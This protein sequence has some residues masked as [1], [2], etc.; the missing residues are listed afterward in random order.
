MSR[1]SGEDAKRGTLTLAR[2]DQEGDVPQLGQDSQ[3]KPIWRD[4]AFV[5]QFCDA[6][7][8]DTSLE[9]GHIAPSLRVLA[10]GM[11]RIAEMKGT[12]FFKTFS[13]REKA[14][15]DKAAGIFTT[16]AKIA[17]EYPQQSKDAGLMSVFIDRVLTELEK[18]PQGT[19]FPISGGWTGEDGGHAIM[20]VVERTSGSKG[21][22]TIC[23]TGQGV[24]HHPSSANFHPKIK[25][26][27]SIVLQ[28]V[29]WDRLVN[30]GFWAF[31]FA[32]NVFPEKINTPGRFYNRIVPYLKPQ[33]LHESIAES[34]DDPA[35]EWRSPQRS[36]ICYHK[37]CLEV[38]RYVYRRMGIS[39][40][41]AKIL[42]MLM[43]Y[44][45]VQMATNDLQAVNEID[46]S[47]RMLIQIATRQLAL[48][49]SK[50]PKHGVN[51]DAS[52]I[53]AVTA[54]V[55]GVK[56]QLANTRVT[57]DPN[58]SPPLLELKDGQASN[59]CWPYFD[60]VVRSAARDRG[61]EET[62][63]PF[64]PL[65]LDKLPRPGEINTMEK[66]IWTLR[67]LDKNCVL[68]RQESVNNR[69][70]LT[71]AL[72]R[73]VLTAVVPVPRPPPAEMK[74]EL[75]L[76][77]R[78][79]HL[80]DPGSEGAEPCIW[81]APMAY[82]V[83][84]DLLNLL[85]RIIM[86]YCGATFSS[87]TTPAVEGSRMVVSGCILALLDVAFRRAA[88]DHPSPATAEWIE[89]KYSF[90]S[91][92]KPL[93]KASEHKVTGAPVLARA[94]ASLREYFEIVQ[95][96]DDKKG[97]R[98]LFVWSATDMKKECGFVA[99][100]AQRIGLPVSSPAYEFATSFPSPEMIM[101]ELPELL[102]L[103]DVSLLAQ[104]VAAPQK[105]PKL[106]MYSAKKAFLNWSLAKGGKIEVKFFGD[107]VP[108][109]ASV[110]EQKSLASPAAYLS[111]DV[112]S[113]DDVLYTRELPNFE[114][115]LYGQDCEL[116]MTYLT[117][118]RLR[119]PLVLSFF[120][121]AERIRAF[122][123]EAIRK[124]LEATLFEPGSW[125][126][127][128][129]GQRIPSRVPETP[130]KLST[131]YGGLLTELSLSPMHIVESLNELIRLAAN[132][133]DLKY[134]SPGANTV[135]YIVRMCSRIDGYIAHL[136]DCAARGADWGAEQIASLK[137]ARASLR[138]HYAFFRMRDILEGWGADAVRQKNWVPSI[139][140]A[141]HSMM[142]NAHDSNEDLVADPEAAQLYLANALFVTT[143]HTFGLNL[144]DDVALGVPEDEI[145]YLLDKQRNAIVRWFASI[146]DAKTGADVGPNLSKVLDAVLAHATRSGG[147]QD[148]DA[149][150]ELSGADEKQASTGRWRSK[151]GYRYARV[152]GGGRESEVIDLQCWQLTV[153]DQN[154]RAVGKQIVQHPDRDY[155]DVF[156]P[157]Y[158]QCAEITKS[159]K[160]R[161]IKIVG[162]P[163]VDYELE[164]WKSAA[165]EPTPRPI[166]VLSQR[167]YGVDMLSENEGWVL[168]IFHPVRKHLGLEEIEFYMPNSLDENA[169]SCIISANINV[170]GKGVLKE[171]IV[172]RAQ[173]TVDVYNVFYNGDRLYRRLVYSSDARRSAGSNADVYATTPEADKRKA[174]LPGCARFQAGNSAATNPGSTSIVIRR[175]VKG[176]ER[177]ERYLPRRCLQ[178]IIP[179]VLLDRYLFWQD[180]DG[181]IV[182]EAKKQGAEFCI[183]MRMTRSVRNADGKV[184]EVAGP[185]LASP[186]EGATTLIACGATITREL[187]PGADSELK[188]QRLLDPFTA[189]QG[190]PLA[191][192]GRVISRIENLSHV[193]VWTDDAKASGDSC[194]IQAVELPRLNLTFKLTGDGSSGKRLMSRDLG[195]KFIT[196][197]RSS[198][199]NRQSFGLPNSLILEQSDSLKFILVP[200]QPFIRP[201]VEQCPFST[202][203]TINP[204]NTTW[205]S[206]LSNAF[207]LYPVHTSESFS[208]TP[209]LASTL[210]LAAMRFAHRRYVEA[211]RLAVAV[212][213]DVALT[214]E[215][216]GCL[217]LFGGCDDDKHPDA[218]AVRLHMHR[219]LLDSGAKL[220]WDLSKE[221]EGYISKLS[222]ITAE[223]RLRPTQELAMIKLIQKPS[224]YVINRRSYLVAFLQGRQSMVAQKNWSFT[225]AGG[226]TT[227]LDKASMV[228]ID[229]KNAKKQKPFGGK[230]SV[231][232]EV[233]KQTNFDEGIY[234]DAAAISLVNNINQINFKGRD[235]GGFDKK[236]Q[237]FLFLYRLLS[238]SIRCTIANRP[239]GH[240]LGAIA[241]GFIRTAG[242]T[243][244]LRIA[245]GYFASMISTMVHLPISKATG[246]DWSL[247]AKE[248]LMKK[249]YKGEMTSYGMLVFKGVCSYPPLFTMAK[250]EP[251]YGLWAV[252]WP[253]DPAKIKEGKKMLQKKM[254]TDQHKVLLQLVWRWSRWAQEARSSAYWPRK[255][256]AKSTNSLLKPA[257]AD[258]DRK[259]RDFVSP[260][261]L[262]CSLSRRKLGSSLTVAGM[263][264]DAGE[265]RAFASQPLSTKVDFGRFTKKAAAD[266]S[267]ILQDMPFDLSRHP[268]LQSSLAKGL[269]TR[270]GNDIKLL[271]QRSRN[272]T[273]TE[274]T[275][276]SAGELAAYASGSKSPDSA[277]DLLFE[278]RKKLSAVREADRKVVQKCIAEAERIANDIDLHK[279][280]SSG[281]GSTTTG[282]TGETRATRLNFYLRRFSGQEVVMTIEHLLSMYVSAQHPEDMRK[283]NP[284]LDRGEVDSAMNAVLMMLLHTSRIG[285]VN[286]TMGSLDDM[287][288]QLGKCK[289]YQKP[290]LGRLKKEAASLVMKLTNA[291]HYFHSGDNP[292]SQVKMNEDPAFAE[293]VEREEAK[294]TRSTFDPRFLLFEFMS[295]FYMRKKQVRLIRTFL[296][297]EASGKS[298]I[299]QMIMGAGK[300]TV[301]SPILSL[302]LANGQRLVVLV[303][304]LN[305]VQMSR[306]VMRAFFSNVI[307]K[308]IFTLTFS[309]S[310]GKRS[311]L[312]GIYDRLCTKLQHCMDDRGVCV[313]APTAVKSVLIK[314]MEHLTDAWLSPD[315]SKARP[316]IE[317]AMS[318]RNILAIFK[319]SALI[320]D[321]V[322]ALL[323]PLRSELNFPIGA[324]EEIDFLERGYRF[325]LPIHLVD[326]MCYVQHRELRFTPGYQNSTEAL[327]IL[328]KLCKAVE[329]G[330]D[331]NVS[332]FQRSPHLAVLDRDYFK[333]EVRPLLAQWLALWMREN[334]FK[335]LPV[336]EI[337]PYLVD[338]PIANP[339]VGRKVRAAVKDKHS[340]QMLNLG[341]DWLNLIGPHCLSMVDRVKF[342]VLS[343]SDQKRLQTMYKGLVITESRKLCAVPFVG[344]D[345]PS[346][347]SEFA[348]PDITISLTILAYRYGGLRRDMFEQMLD[349][350][351]REMYNQAGG[352]D[353]AD[354]PAA[355]MYKRW[356]A[357]LGVRLRGE[358]AEIEYKAGSVIAIQDTIREG[359]A[360]GSESPVYEWNRWRIASRSGE[361]LKLTF[362]SRM[363][364]HSTAQSRAGETRTVNVSSLE[365]TNVVMSLDQVDI[366]DVALVGNLFALLG[367]IPQVVDYYLGYVFRVVLKANRFKLSACGQEL[368]GDILFK[369]R[370]GY[371]GTPS[372][373]VP[374][375]LK[376]GYE[377]GADAEMMANLT[378][379][380]VM[381]SITSLGGDWTV[382][383][384]LKKIRT[385]NPPSHALIDTG[386]LITGFSNKEVAQFLLA[387][388]GLP[389]MD[390]VVFL[391]QYD[392]KMVLVRRTGKVVKL[393]QSG[394]G[395]SRRFSFFDQ[396]HT[397]GMDIR[398]A[399]NARAIITLGK[400]M[401]W[402]D[403]AQGA[404]RMRG[405]GQ[406]Q[407]FSILVI[408]EVGALIKREVDGGGRIQVNGQG[409]EK[410]LRRIVAWLL[411]NEV[412][413]QKTQFEQ[414]CLQ[415]VRNVFRKKAVGALF[416]NPGKVVGSRTASRG[417]NNKTHGYAIELL[418]ENIGP[419]LDVV[420]SV[421]EPVNL[422]D[423][424]RRE[425]KENG[426]RL[427]LDA[428][429]RRDIDTAISALE[430]SQNSV[431]AK[432]D[433]AREQKARQFVGEMVQEQH[434]QAEQTE[435]QTRENQIEIEKFAD[436]AY[437][438]GE[439]EQRSWAWRRLR[440][441]DQKNSSPDGEEDEAK[442]KRDAE[443]QK[444]Q[445]SAVAKLARLLGPKLV[446]GTLQTRQTAEVLK[447]SIVALFFDASWDPSAIRMAEILAGS[448][449]SA[450]KA[451]KPFEV[452]FISSDPDKEAFASFIGGSPFFA[453]PFTEWQLRSGLVK[454]F[455]A[456]QKPFI[457]VLGPD[458]E[459]LNADARQDICADPRGFPWPADNGNAKNT[460]VQTMTALSGLM[461]YPAS[462]YRIKGKSSLRFPTWMYISENFHRQSWANREKRLKNVCVILEWVPDV[463]D[464]V[465]ARPPNTKTHKPLTA[466]QKQ[467]LLA[468]FSALDTDG[469]GSIEKSEV[470]GLLRALNRDPDFILDGSDRKAEASSSAVCVAS[471]DLDNDGSVAFPELVRLIER[472]D[473]DQ[474]ETGRHFVAVSLAEAETI[475][476]AMQVRNE[477]GKPLVDGDDA[478]NPK[479]VIALWVLDMA[480]RMRR[481]KAGPKPLLPEPIL[482]A[483][484]VGYTKPPRFQR[485]TMLQAFRYINSNMYFT[486]YE[487]GI[488]INGMQAN[489]MAARK[490]FFN[491]VRTRRRRNGE[492][493]MA[494]PLAMLFSTADEYQLIERRA[495]R[496]RLR[497]AILSKGLMLRDAFLKF[498]YD[499]SGHLSE[500]ELY[501][502]LR[503]LGV[504]VTAGETARLIRDMDTDDSGNIDYE[505]FIAHLEARDDE[506]AAEEAKVARQA[507]QDG[508]FNKQKTQPVQLV[509]MSYQCSR[510]KKEKKES[511]MSCPKVP[512]EKTE[513]K[514]SERK[515]SDAKAKGRSRPAPRMPIRSVAVNGS[516][517]M[518]SRPLYSKSCD[519]VCTVGWGG[520]KN[521]EQCSDTRE[522]TFGTTIVPRI[523]GSNPKNF[524]RIMTAVIS[525]NMETRKAIQDF[526]FPVCEGFEFVGRLLRNL[527]R[528][529]FYVWKPR[530]P[531]AVTRTHVSIG[532]VIT[533]SRSEPNNISCRVIHKR[534][535]RPPKG[536]PIECAQCT[537]SDSE[538]KTMSVW[539]NEDNVLSMSWNDNHSFPTGKKWNIN[540]RLTVAV[541]VASQ[542]RPDAKQAASGPPK[543]SGFKVDE[544]ACSVCT[545]LNKVKALGQKCKV[546]TSP[547]KFNPAQ[548]ARLSG[549]SA[550]PPDEVAC[551]VCTLHNK[552]KA[553]GQ[554]CKVC[555][556]PLKLSAANK[557]WLEGKSK[558]AARI[559]KD[560]T[561]PHAAEA[562]AKAGAAMVNISDP[563]EKMKILADA[564]AARGLE[565]LDQGHEYLALRFFYDAIALRPDW[566]EY[567]AG[568]ALALSATGDDITALDELAKVMMPEAKAGCRRRKTFSLRDAQGS[569]LAWRAAVAALLGS[570]NVKAAEE[571]CEMGLKAHRGNKELKNASAEVKT[572]SQ[573]AGKAYPIIKTVGQ[574]IILSSS[575]CPAARKDAVLFNADGSVKAAVKVQGI[576]WGSWGARL[577]KPGEIQ[578]EFVA[579]DKSFAYRLKLLD[580]GVW[581][582]SPKGRSAEASDKT[583]VVLDEEARS[584][585][586]EAEELLA[587]EL[588][589]QAM[590]VGLCKECD[591]GIGKQRQKRGSGWGW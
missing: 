159:S 365:D 498:D 106:G 314:F 436:L 560:K 586:V 408:P 569:P 168:D 199:L 163:G 282:G 331:P 550:L 549:K 212:H 101:W 315:T 83:Q 422:I 190:S 137:K 266:T 532:L 229:W 87:Q 279:D 510:C 237:G 537:V 114:N 194:A 216:T 2:M 119:I 352:R 429:E 55:L 447:G 552:I 465:T 416:E 303:V 381:T 583:F 572:W 392:D 530:V 184:S 275:L 206:N 162:T 462:A 499:D 483:K 142:I 95:K 305:L 405:I 302:I 51:L 182:G 406:G 577:G 260:V 272:A 280:S 324:R 427:S 576:T 100:V 151:G 335:G 308:P 342:G 247:E 78:V 234:E 283:L 263:T 122:Q 285:Q 440:D 115:V 337:V 451:G 563:V 589:S 145:F 9:G 396:V 326:A 27:N 36:G 191:S 166:G 253:Y 539:T 169:T 41:N 48:S 227:Y 93:L 154:L 346:R 480:G 573:F 312:K 235:F 402:R 28:D 24:G 164:E 19:P 434:V 284:H 140:C 413:M 368:G 120:A 438:R 157:V 96:L 264:L 5:G 448:R 180:T 52:D 333:R 58:E 391:N 522:V 161:A 69:E 380:E 306:S 143:R 174:P 542:G 321:E 513:A 193:L 197:D 295:N 233:C 590:V 46:E 241:W 26:K 64:V 349:T 551:S 49:A 492:D 67:L 288:E 165:K 546:C 150:A 56:D 454:E 548:I 98:P 432:R 269:V 4:G 535:R 257:A 215:E 540:K 505:E 570:G 86:H 410:Q 274:L 399:L 323:H 309:R 419:T 527:G 73:H 345:V 372:S 249:N 357:L 289:S 298:R 16:A 175:M 81:A 21:R 361:Q 351:I 428:S 245:K 579:S 320:M 146:G 398:Q 588:P 415:N 160:M 271:A 153:A 286:W 582:T 270:I 6:F 37:C 307:K 17:E 236:K 102:Y 437:D 581:S 339:E 293:R 459:I 378:S 322:D 195:G 1:F 84:V 43:R 108:Q 301:A 561:P 418:R 526:Y 536:R 85:H 426:S 127:L 178:G 556:S 262:D 509:R 458:G 170:N 75:G 506:D 475:R 135:F 479:T 424:V 125:Q 520:F 300:S 387:D 574:Q 207:Y 123:S 31:V 508:Q 240:A 431:E 259:S 528:K 544:V 366:N 517:T 414:L 425:V 183:R 74:S 420:A 45:F 144:S 319:K 393:S 32:L 189:P 128:T 325:R 18:L 313:S 221:V 104:F 433:S 466:D 452:V 113:E 442:R 133:R 244:R 490:D 66:A 423:K 252:N 359:S 203:L 267:S 238:G 491:G 121:T 578:V 158:L 103:R 90:V 587:L 564:S 430:S 54:L 397:V 110:G 340:L 167:R 497:R 355:R 82:R 460:R 374:L 8:Q 327:S 375:E 277:I 200:S 254:D 109:V 33:F 304:P 202:Q 38:T 575:P 453:I 496:S 136:L 130:Q 515:G 514:G 310:K 201:V 138:E 265:L 15:I 172:R 504:R 290:Q 63:I 132:L 385:Q 208:K 228:T 12:G 111:A 155:L 390:G 553:L 179:D 531:A 534:F 223:C 412:K 97:A 29:E 356:V 533:E 435:E 571:A 373:L 23:N 141:I 105:V 489:P 567:S 500:D 71:A 299:E 334:K 131:F 204:H 99:A 565:L 464:V 591:A 70:Y 268:K 494:T 256:S 311:E 568:L 329:K 363:Q 156:G 476:Y 222:H 377:R 13:S 173:G 330:Y 297:F 34:M 369:T 441:A 61:D 585:S 239:A 538:K 192:I 584:E 248:P 281:W 370:M 547:L 276:M 44:V 219:I 30:S 348:H 250:V 404:Y 350:L 478:K 211:Y 77:Q 39:K 379:P 53:E 231:P 185:S 477:L 139:R 60:R 20:L 554:K 463:T 209:T 485:D 484:S 217:L 488:L 218:H 507:S 296:E 545:L 134:N 470:R 317:L 501:G 92:L 22:F 394:I 40:S 360:D 543:P 386:A 116:L 181:D 395:K 246:K 519:S 10:Y 210:Y 471:S 328:N 411:V 443:V 14:T 529:H 291:R 177:W 503:W 450:A 403:Y 25:F 205:S 251:K 343:A 481:K 149:G 467:R 186:G 273:Q 65:T 388:G 255:K 88:R 417:S 59:L 107:E 541:P 512:E 341:H 171:C 187:V 382:E 242:K 47:D 80:E 439:E 213:T 562:A 400:D 557:A 474:E 516:V 11:R 225:A 176:K 487:L 371:S 521:R 338:G 358:D 72:I 129:V 493:V 294:R 76:S 258:V 68:L 220:P 518:L 91:P 226:W 523:E 409:L 445:E 421:P 35:C 232:D 57:Q 347:S 79:G 62:R 353:Y 383:S 525:G 473:L 42:S 318:L 486:D 287:I 124:L 407:T 112:R 364:P 230:Y 384:M 261:F 89:G 316:N 367:A 461:F 126:S 278:L 152:L 336:K 148:N 449:N 332:A 446:D 401:T 472:G 559:E 118:P 524:E 502:A 456:T 555:M 455:G 495:M 580:G 243:S 566:D 292:P 469:S 50:L 362:E 457:V 482:L 188:P 117:V 224:V 511:E 214:P 94:L 3:A 147:G 444:R 196:N 376:C 468:A 354:T 198:L 558:P 344:K 7:C 389:G